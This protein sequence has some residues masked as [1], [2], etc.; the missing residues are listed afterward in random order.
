MKWEETLSKWLGS[1]IEVHIEDQVG[2]DPIAPPKKI[3]LEKIRISEDR[4]YML[5]YMNEHQFLAIPLK[6]EH[7]SLTC[8]EHGTV[9]RS[10][11]IAAQLVYKVEFG[12]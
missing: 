1:H 2:L 6:G 10:F 12:S 9:L 3:K 11:D 8:T 7:T 5:M 4:E